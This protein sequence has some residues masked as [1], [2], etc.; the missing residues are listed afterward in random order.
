MMFYVRLWNTLVKNC[1]QDDDC[2]PIG[3]YGIMKLAGED[4]VKDYHRRG[5]FDYVIIRPSAVYGPLDVR[6]T[7]FWYADHR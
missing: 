7:A 4:L 3:Q 5:C 1:Q 2:H 6:T